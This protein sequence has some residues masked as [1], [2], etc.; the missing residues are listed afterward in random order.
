V[1]AHLF[2]FDIDGTLA[3]F[4]GITGRAFNRTFQELH[5]QPGPWGKV[6]PHGRTDRMILRECFAVAGVD[7][8]FDANFK[9][10]IARYLRN[11]EE[12]F[13]TASGPRVM[14]GV[15]ELLERLDA[16]SSAFLALGTGNVERAAHIKLEH[17][18]LNTF[19]PIGGFGDH[20]DERKQ[21]IADAIQNAATHYECDFA[22]QRSWVIGDTPYD[23]EAGQAL[24]LR[25]L[26]VATGGLHTLE[27]LRPFT[28][29]V[30]LE[31]LA[32]TEGVIKMIG[33]DK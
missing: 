26:A 1:A 33:F 32:D 28:P 17:L 14:P 4:A 13:Q 8:D 9:T 7:G 16:D 11:L 22:P 6:L 12:A 21:V 25:T 18:N 31:S 15:C 27:D 3:T 30:L 23:I 29:D 19:F 24:G 2:I 5:G 20:A 10:F